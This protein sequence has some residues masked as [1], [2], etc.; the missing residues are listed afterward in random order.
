[1]KETYFKIY[2]LLEQLG[3][4]IPRLEMVD[5]IVRQSSFKYKK[6]DG[7][8]LVQALFLRSCYWLDKELFDETYL[9]KK[10]QQTLSSIQNHHLKMVN[11][12]AILLEKGFPL[13]Y[14][15]LEYT[16][17]GPNQLGNYVKIFIEQCHKQHAFLHPETLGQK[18]IFLSQKLQKQ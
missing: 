3:N 12:G 10:S 9:Y 13:N 4:P 11:I 14:N 5:R 17:Q 1:M 7:A 16:A 2:I 8:D 15:T 18:K 6:E